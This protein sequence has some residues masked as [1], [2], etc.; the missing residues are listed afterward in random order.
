MPKAIIVN[1][2]GRDHGD[3]FAPLAADGGLPVFPMNSKDAMSHTWDGCDLK[4]YADP[5]DATTGR[6]ISYRRTGI[7]LDTAITFTD[8][9][10]QGQSFKGMPHFLHLNTT[11]KPWNKANLLVP[12]SRAATWADVHLAHPLW[13]EG[14]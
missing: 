4:L 10:A 11:I 8:Y 2:D 3:L 6:R 9:Y 14:K 13:P 12:I 5:T 7:P 1:V